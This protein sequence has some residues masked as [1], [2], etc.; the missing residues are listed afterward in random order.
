MA[1]RNLILLAVFLVSCG[2]CA[3]TGREDNATG[4]PQAPAAKVEPLP[5]KSEASSASPVP[6]ASSTSA[7]NGRLTTPI[8]PVAVS[9]GSTVGSHA[10]EFELTR[11]NGE[12]FALTE[13]RGQL[14]V[15]NF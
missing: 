5:V 11:L 13:L 12:P 15:L 2:A 4:S 1:P 9:F 8:P 10:Y 6:A 14:V 7:P 3:G